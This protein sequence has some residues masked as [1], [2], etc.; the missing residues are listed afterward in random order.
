MKSNAMRQLANG[1]QPSDPSKNTAETAEFR[2]DHIQAIRKPT[3]LIQVPNQRLFGP[4]A[5][6]RYL[7]ICEDTLKK[8]TDLEQIPAF[9]LNGRRAYRF[10]DLERFI[11]SLPGWYDDSGEKSAK[12]VEKG[13]HDL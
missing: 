7:G 12:V 11:E 9:K 3:A 1:H 4:K 13:N 8:I 2:G 5:A 6:A 10:E